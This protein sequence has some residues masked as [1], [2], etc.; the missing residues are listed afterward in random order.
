M[1]SLIFVQLC[2]R[3][4]PVWTVLS[5]GNTSVSDQSR[6]SASPQSPKLKC[7]FTYTCTYNRLQTDV[8]HNAVIHISIF[9][10]FQ[11]LVHI[12]FFGTALVYSLQAFFHVHIYLLLFLIII[13]FLPCPISYPIFHHFPSRPA[14]PSQCR[15]HRHRSQ[16]LKTRRSLRPPA[17]GAARRHGSRT[18]GGEGRDVRAQPGDV[19]K[20][21]ARGG[22]VG[23]L[24]LFS[25]SP[26]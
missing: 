6:Q 21:R 22:R 7:T 1:V 4:E 10:I 5:D 23:R 16:P 25:V 20:P 11:R 24:F 13:T 9:H 2:C 12:L 26:I 19:Q 15:D 3:I 17:C 14:V 18:G 8:A